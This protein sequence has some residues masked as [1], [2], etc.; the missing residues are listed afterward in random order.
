MDHP[1]FDRVFEQG[2]SNL[3]VKPR[4]ILDDS[5]TAI[6]AKHSAIAQVQRN[7][8]PEWLEAFRQALERVAR[9][10]H[11]FTS[12]A[13]WEEFERQ[14]NRPSQHEPRAAGAVV[15]KAIKDRVI[16]P[17]TNLFWKSNRS[18]CH[19]RP[20]QVYQSLIYSGERGL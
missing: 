5:E 11:R 13:I 6:R 17:V 2:E 15:V 19:H 12:D 4:S 8:N 16:F 9:S 3:P 10:Q 14:S 7:A 1:L 20:K 18:T